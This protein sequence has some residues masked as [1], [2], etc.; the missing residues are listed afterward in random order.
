MRTGSNIFAT[1]TGIVVTGLLFGVLAVLLQQAGNPGNMGIC[2]VCFNRDIAG[3]IGLHRAAVVQYLRP[4]IMGMVLGA[5]GA[6]LLF[7]E[8]KPRGGS[9]PITRFLLGAVAGI[10]ALVFLGCPWRVI[11]R[12]AG[13]DL[14]ALVG[15][16][17]FFIGILIGSACLKRGFTLK[18]SY[19]VSVSEGSVL[20][21]VM[22]ALLILVLTVPALFKASEAGPGS[23]HAPFWIALIVA[24]VVGALAQKSRLCMVGGLRDAVMLGDFHLLY[25]FAAIF[26]VTLVGNL[27]MNRFNLGFALQP[28]A[29]SAHVW[30]LLGMVLVGWGSVLLGGCPLRQLILAAQGNG[31]SAVTVFGMIVGAALA[32]NFGLAGNPDSKNEAGQLVVGGISTA[33]K[34]AVIVGLVVLLVIAMWNMPKKETTK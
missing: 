20:P 32:H 34:V 22:A 11:L 15:L 14:N 6:A 12:L 7:G 31:D 30:N 17:G 28:I 29:H 9:A 27:A 19:E 25:G 8:Y 5:F 1:T 18:R 16:I 24:L 10:G 2:V 33:G 4:E 13:G 21:T 3:A 23:M 26:V